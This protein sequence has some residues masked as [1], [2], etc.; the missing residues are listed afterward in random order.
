VSRA[1]HPGGAVRLFDAGLAKL[2]GAGFTDEE[3]GLPLEAFIAAVSKTRES[4]RQW[5]SGVTGPPGSD[6]RPRIGT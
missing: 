1:E 3:A 4:A 6:E 5:A 2:E